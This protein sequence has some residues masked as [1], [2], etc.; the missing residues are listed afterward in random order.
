VVAFGVYQLVNLTLLGHG[1]A[2]EPV[3]AGVTCLGFALTWSV[4]PGAAAVFA[5]RRTAV[6]A[7]VLTAAA[8]GMV[9]GM[10]GVLALY[11][12]CPA[13][14]VMHLV[15]FHALVLPLCAVLGALLGRRVV[16]V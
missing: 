4:I 14:D 9:G 10:G 12:K 3:A 6:L 8:A 1:E 16:V 13:S 15:I 11:L 7:P 5:V 2:A